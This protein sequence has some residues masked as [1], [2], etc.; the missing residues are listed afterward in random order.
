MDLALNDNI[1]GMHKFSVLPF[2]KNLV[3][4]ETEEGWT[5]ILAATAQ[6][7]DIDHKCIKFLVEQGGDLL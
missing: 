3:N 1:E 7:S 4:D 2:F 6:P 5:A